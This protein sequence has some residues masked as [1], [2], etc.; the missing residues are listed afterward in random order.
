MQVIELGKGRLI[1]AVLRLPYGFAM[2]DVLCKNELIDVR[3]G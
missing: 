1:R 3:Q 2:P